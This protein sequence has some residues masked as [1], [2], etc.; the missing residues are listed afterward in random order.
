MNNIILN[1]Y[2]NQIV[3]IS[4]KLLVFDMAGTVI[5]EKG[6]VYDTLYNTIKKFKKNITPID[7]KQWHGCNKYE[8]L[9]HYI[10]KERLSISK[11]VVYENFNNELKKQYFESSEIKLM[12]EN[13]PDLFTKIRE[14]NI[15]IALNTGYNKNIQKTII[16]KLKINSFIDDFISS[17]EVSKGR[18][19]PHMINALLKRN[20]INSP[21]E[22]I[23]IGDTRNDILEGLN[24]GCISS[25]GVLS[26]AGDVKEL[27]DANYILNN[28]MDINLL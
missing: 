18:P 27:E 13:I 23:K 22:V 8:V 25:I 9:D 20:N 12:D 26:G 16:K 1:T 28:I 19:E 6:I 7:I 15:K 2:R 10:E 17:E 14:N 5:N 24:A 4:C 21:K 11:Y 3:N